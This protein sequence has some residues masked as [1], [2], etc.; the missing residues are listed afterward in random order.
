MNTTTINHLTRLDYIKCL[1]EENRMGEALDNMKSMCTDLESI[2]IGHARRFDDRS[3]EI[4]K[5]LVRT[6][7]HNWMFL[8]ETWV[9]LI[10]MNDSQI[11]LEI[12]NGISV[13]NKFIVKNAEGC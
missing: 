9:K 8:N 12:S 5:A 6:K 1:I 2:C 7:P 11:H 4:P 10:G 13:R 3:L